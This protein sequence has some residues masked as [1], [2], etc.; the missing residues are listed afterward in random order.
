MANRS[1]DHE[2]DEHPASSEYQRFSTTTTFDN[3]KAQECCAEIDA[4]EDHL[5]HIRVADSGTLENDSTVVEEVIRASELLKS[6]E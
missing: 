5:S 3:V 4:S 2:T 6:L 1:E